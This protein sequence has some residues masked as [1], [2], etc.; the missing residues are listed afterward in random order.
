M[1]KLHTKYLSCNT[2]VA[3]HLSHDT[4]CKHLHDRQ[5]DSS[6]YALL[7]IFFSFII[8]K[9]ALSNAIYL[10]LLSIQEQVVGFV[11]C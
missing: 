3:L 4:S 8:L 9:G 2:C 7:C 6:I 11:V 5:N 10:R 1:K